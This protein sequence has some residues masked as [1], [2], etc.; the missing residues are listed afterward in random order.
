MHATQWLKAALVV[1]GLLVFAGTAEAQWE[2]EG[3]HVFVEANGGGGFQI[4]N[5]DY[6]PSS[7]A[8]DFQFPV[9]Y[10]F[11]VGATGGVM[12]GG[13]IAL[14]VNY[15]YAESQTRDGSIPGVLNNVEGRIKYH[16]AVVGLR[17]Y[18][19][20]GFGAVRSELG[21]GVIFPFHTELELNYGPGLAVLPQPITGTGLMTTNF[22]VG[23]GG[24]AKIGY[25][26]PIWGPLYTALD[27]EL[28]LFQS[29][30]SGETTRFNNFV[31]DF[32]ATPPVAVT[33]TVFNG[34]NGAR[35]RSESVG[36]ARAMLSLGAAF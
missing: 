29:D 7:S 14:V 26:I 10:G 18:V 28:Q 31:T 3:R 32:T 4:G 34:D 13:P 6:L 30:N 20:T 22:S 2:M 33:A 25:Q 9:V 12:L 23:V 21:V 16:T 5:T 19:P 24:Q 36:A 11:G 15:E 17:L 27:L 1:C 35:P 8:T